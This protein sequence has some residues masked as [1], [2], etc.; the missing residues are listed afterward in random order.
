MTFLFFTFFL[1]WKISSS[2]KTCNFCLGLPTFQSYKLECHYLFCKNFK[3]C[4]GARPPRANFPPIPTI[5]TTLS[6]TFLSIRSI[7]AHNHCPFFSQQA[8]LPRLV[9]LLVQ[10]HGWRSLGTW[11]PFTLCYPGGHHHLLEVISNLLHD[12]SGWQLHGAAAPH[13]QM[14]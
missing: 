9:P 2:N 5:N 12:N 7:I 13:W 10:L 11:V 6:F 1:S 3:H 4:P 8:Y 14:L